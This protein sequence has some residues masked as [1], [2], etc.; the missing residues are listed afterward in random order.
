MKPKSGVVLLADDDEI[1]AA[2]IADILSADVERVDAV[3]NGDACLSYIQSTPPDVLI[4]DVMLPDVNGVRLLGRLRDD[5]ATARVPV[6]MI[7]SLDE[8]RYRRDAER[9]GA[10]AFIR[11]PFEPEDVRRAVLTALEAGSPEA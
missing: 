1:I 5:P 2:L 7:S 4:L 10:K 9:L 6:V 3:R 11:K 8:R